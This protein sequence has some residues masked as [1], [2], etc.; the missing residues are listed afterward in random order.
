VKAAL[1]D[2]DAAADAHA[3]AVRTIEEFAG[4]LSDGRRMTLLSRPGIVALRSSV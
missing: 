4:G 3:A 1:G 2:D